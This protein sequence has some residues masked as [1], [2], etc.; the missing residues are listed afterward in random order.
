MLDPIPPKPLPLS[1]NIAV[2][3]LAAGG[4][5][6]M[7][8]PKQL[9]PW[10]DSTLLGHTVN[11]AL[12]LPCNQVV[13]VL[14]AHAEEI[15]ETIL[16][17]AVLVFEHERWEEGMGTSIAWGISRLIKSVPEIDGILILLADQPLVTPTYLN[18]I[19][20]SFSP[21]K[22]QIIATSYDGQKQGVPALFDAAY[23]DE[24]LTLKGDKGAREIL[25]K[26]K[27]KLELHSAAGQ[28]SDIDTLDDYRALYA[29]NHQW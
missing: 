5:K 8:A 14:G 21:G 15:K 18:T 6:R 12:Q 29:A 24:L 22:Q 9:L 4:S 3:I 17:D 26:Y 2:L 1:T 27:S 16:T 25:Q 11:I 20:A 19:M 28:L 23:L 13:V 7:G 10:G